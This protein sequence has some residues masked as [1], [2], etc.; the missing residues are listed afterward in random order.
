MV[1]D[2]TG[3]SVVLAALKNNVNMNWIKPQSLI[4]RLGLKFITGRI[5]G[6]KTNW[7]P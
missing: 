2:G 1:L 5:S 4:C 6:I 7:T 3:K